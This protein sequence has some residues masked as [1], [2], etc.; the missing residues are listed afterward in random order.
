MF[1]KI[2][3]S[4]VIFA[5]T[6]SALAQSKL[7][8]EVILKSAFGN[9]NSATKSSSVA[10]SEFVKHKSV[11]EKNGLDCVSESEKETPEPV[12]LQV[13]FNAGTVESGIPKTYVVFSGVPHSQAKGNGRPCGV[14]IG[15]AVFV[16]KSNTWKVESI[17]W[18]AA[19]DGT[20]GFAPQSDSMKLVEIGR[21]KHG[22]AIEQADMNQGREWS[23][24]ILL[25]PVGAQFEEVWKSALS[26]NNG[27]SCSDD[28]DERK[29]E[30]YLEPCYG[31]E[32]SYRLRPI[33][34]TV[35]YELIATSRGTSAQTAS[36][37]TTIEP[38][39]WTRTFRWKAGHFLET[40]RR[41]NAPDPNFKIKELF[42]D[43]SN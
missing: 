41:K 34:G 17:S 10:F 27:G 43:S 37:K 18:W 1:R 9:Y 24:V 14:A 29:Q 15:G 21:G 3:L 22:V 36:E 26:N 39:N 12:D 5:V 31:H 2:I 8:D 33:P 25:A 6:S 19:N 38:E 42:G 16:E 35:Y 32:I 20:Y 40:S 13:I 28:P 23:W 7:A 4:A 30:S 11:Q